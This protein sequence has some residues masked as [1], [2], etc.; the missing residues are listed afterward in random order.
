MSI[1]KQET[2][3]K[4]PI[5]LKIHSI[6]EHTPHM[7]DEEYDALVEDIHLNGQREPVVVYQQRV[8]DGRHRI[9]ACKDLGL[10][11]KV[12]FAPRSWT[13]EDAIAFALSTEVRRNLDSTQ[14][15]IRAYNEYKRRI[16]DSKLKKLGV[17]KIAKMFGVSIAS[18]D[19]VIALKTNRGGRL[20]SEYIDIDSELNKMFNSSKYKCDFGS[21]TDDYFNMCEEFVKPKPTRSLISFVKA[22][23]LIN[24]APT[25]TILPSREPSVDEIF[26]SRINTEQGKIQFQKFINNVDPTKALNT[27]GINM[28]IDYI[29]RIYTK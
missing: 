7:T 20:G 10:K 5:V 2:T 12:V 25:L 24:E 16:E 19:A 3:L 29:N 9:R 1:D 13:D 26:E 23:K 28:L 27:D 17:A 18:L 11:C 22:I 4:D 8:I 21:L 15:A 6:A 14:K